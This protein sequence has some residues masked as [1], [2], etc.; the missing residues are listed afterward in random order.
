MLFPLKGIPRSTFYLKP[1]WKFE[2]DASSNDL[3]KHRATERTSVFLGS[4]SYRPSHMS[5]MLKKHRW[6]YRRKRICKGTSG[7]RVNILKNSFCLR[8]QGVFPLFDFQIHGFSKKSLYELESL[9]APKQL[10]P[11]LIVR[12]RS[13]MSWSPSQ[14]YTIYVI[15]NSLRIINTPDY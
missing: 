12:N 1:L 9:N 6:S 14:K 3:A 4:P 7:K 5:G 11:P 8:V 10:P 13:R 15:I 2:H